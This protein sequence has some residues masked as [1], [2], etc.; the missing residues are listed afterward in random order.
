VA[1][2]IQN[3]ECPRADGLALSTGYRALNGPTKGGSEAMNVAELRDLLANVPP[4][5]RVDAMINGY[6]HDAYPVENVDV[7]ELSN[8]VHIVVINCIDYP[9]LKTA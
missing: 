8:G 3:L 2:S 7:V 9:P 1:G 4:Q 6:P 5:A